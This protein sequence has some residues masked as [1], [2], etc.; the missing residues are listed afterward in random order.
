MCLA[1]ASL[2]YRVTVVDPRGYPIAHPNLT[3]REA[4]YDELADDDRG[5]DA[6]VVL[7]AVEHFGLGHYEGDEPGRDSADEET[8]RDLRER[9]APGGRLVLTAPFGIAKVDAFQRVYDEA[10][11]D[12][13]LSGWHVAERCHY[14]QDDDM[15]WRPGSVDQTK[16]RPGV[17][18]LVAH[19]PGE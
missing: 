9:L 13:L 6:A 14:W 11:I 17:V 8:L 18:L 4:R 15:S 1:L 3:V 16:G 12:E 7:S 2:G 5:F 19:A 10:G